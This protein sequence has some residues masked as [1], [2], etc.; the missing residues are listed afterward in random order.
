MAQRSETVSRRIRLLG[1]RYGW[2]AKGSALVAC[3]FMVVIAGF[4]VAGAFAQPGFTIERAEQVD[5]SGSVVG[6]GKDETQTGRVLVHVDGAVANPGV[7]ELTVDSP[8]INDAVSSAGGLVDGADT[9]SMN[10]AA[11]VSDGEKVHV[12]SF[13]E[14]AFA[15][16]ATA[17]VGDGSGAVGNRSQASGLVNIN[18]ANESELQTLNGVGEATASAIVRDRTNNG[19]FASPE[20]LMRITGIG[21]K[22]FDKLKDQIC[23]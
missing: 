8:R 14:E 10:L 11:P 7:Y 1:R 22:K 2:V 18:T 5:A 12:P 19:P 20:D 17:P 9:T 21:E 3:A 13:G 16:V 15:P 23:V 6:S 4:A